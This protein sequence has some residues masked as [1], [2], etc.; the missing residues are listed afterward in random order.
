M[1]ALSLPH[2]LLACARHIAALGLNPGA[3]G[4]LSVREADGMLITPSGLPWEELGT[5]DFVHVDWAGQSQGPRAPSSE[6]QLHRDLYLA[7]SEFGAVI[8]THAPFCTAL[9]CLHREIPS[10]HY[11]VARFGG[12]TVRCARYATY[13]T[14][15]LSLATAEAMADR[16]GCLLGNHG[17][18]VAGRDLRHAQALAIEL[19]SLAEQYWR[20]CQLGTPILLPEDEIARVLEKFK[21]YGVR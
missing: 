7:R 2:Q 8:H 3:A 18:V 5:D 15:A 6:W 19:E 21:G 17:M 9:A 16:N 12:S 20:A 10:F 11:M 1:T 13:G 14:P 4:N